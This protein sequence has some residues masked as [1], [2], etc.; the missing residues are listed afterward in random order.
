MTTD[1]NADQVDQDY[2]SVR[3]AIGSPVPRSL[4]EDAYALDKSLLDSHKSG[5][6]RIKID[7]CADS[8]K[9]T[10]RGLCVGSGSGPPVTRSLSVNNLLTAPTQVMTTHNAPH[11]MRKDF[12]TLGNKIPLGICRSEGSIPLIV[13][14]SEE[15]NRVKLQKST[16]GGPPRSQLQRLRQAEFEACHVGNAR[17]FSAEYDSTDTEV[18]DVTCFDLDDRPNTPVPDRPSRLSPDLPS[19]SPASP[20]TVSVTPPVSPQWAPQT[21]PQWTPNVKQKARITASLTPPL[22]PEW[23]VGQSTRGPFRMRLTPPLTPI[24]RSKSVPKSH[25]P[26]LDSSSRLP[27]DSPR[28]QGGSPR[29]PGGSPRS[30]GRLLPLRDD[31]QEV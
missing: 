16:T 20:L 9:P 1:D 25:A 31:R 17:G 26:G 13:C 24:R 4:G 8:G 11:P 18:S 15:R 12:G 5:H 3:E 14:Q 21:S 6:P 22:S 2:I 27:G 30:P 19:G 29:S 10:A 23:P 28:S 7:V